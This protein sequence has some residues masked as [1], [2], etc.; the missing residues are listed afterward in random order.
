MADDAT[1][2]GSIVGH[3]RLDISDWEAKL[4]E[5]ELKAR[6][7]A[8]VDPDIRVDV[9]SASALAK[10]EAVRVAAEAV[11]GV[12]A[13]PRVSTAASPVSAG[14]AGKV[15]ALTVA[16]A[17]LDAVTAGLEAAQAAD[18]EEM[19]QGSILALRESINME[20]LA[21]AER[22]AAVA[23]VERAAADEA[24]AKAS[25]DSSG[26]DKLRVSRMG[27]IV[28]AVAAL[29]PLLGPLSAYIVG[30][31]GAF[32]GMAAAGVLAVI[33]IRN[34]MKDGTAEGQ[35]YSDGLQTL[36]GDLNGLAATSAT[37]MLSSFQK[38]VGL[39]HA[40][41]PALNGQISV[42]SSMLGNIGTTVLQGV[43]TALRVLNPLFVQAGEYVQDL[44]DGFQ[45][46]T[47]DGGLQKFATYAQQELPK[48]AETLGSLATAALHII[49]ALAPLGNATLTI[50]TGFGNAINALPNGL[51]LTLAVSITGVVI[52]TKAMK[53]L[54]PIINQVK[55]AFTG[56]GGAVP[57]GLIIGF[58]NEI[59]ILGAQG[60]AN[61]ANDMTGMSRAYAA[62]D[63]AMSTGDLGSSKAK[64]AAADISQTLKT[65]KGELGGFAGFVIDT[66]D[67]L[68]KNGFGWLAGPAQA[69][70]QGTFGKAST[71][72]NTYKSATDAVAASQSAA[73]GPTSALTAALQAQST[74]ADMLKTSFDLLNGTN[75]SVEQSQTAMAAANN[76]VTESFAQNGLAIDGSSAAAVANQ[77][78]IQNAA[79]A[80]QANAE[81]I[82]TQTGS[83]NAGTTAFMAS[84]TA[85]EQQLAAQ[86]NLTPAVQ[87][88]IDKLYAIPPELATKLSVDNAAA[89]TA[90]ANTQEALNLLPRT[91]TIGVNMPA[92]TG[93]YKILTNATGGAVPS[94][95]SGGGNGFKPVGTD[96]VPAMLTPKEFVVKA[97]S[98]EHDP[99]FIKAY[100]DNPQQAL[101]NY[102]GKQKQTVINNYF[103]IY[104]STSADA[105][106]QS[107]V[108]FLAGQGV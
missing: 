25:N 79:L 10:L 30:V 6:E 83:T 94:Y 52:A 4:K 75:L 51:L 46:W 37:A 56:L 102:G 59:A 103:T 32:G 84:K 19:R 8:R 57:I 82:T 68:E 93:G 64:K 58:A 29:I 16:M 14:A 55:G 24:G 108:H 77:Q 27:L 106:A 88:Y 96:T 78:A 35:K 65:A 50:L 85:L 66:S 42:F 54:P 28:A 15:D 3:L 80:A 23:A 38:A 72:L 5:A 91:I 63:K 92:T 53:A 48:V 11:D 21:A 43:L 89:L 36:K 97:S 99:Q 7:L 90:I 101:D 33:G 105:T 95:L 60:L 100:N 67:N 69:F 20:A 1:T 34:A 81:A 39:I 73:T 17:K 71:T 74:T 9:D 44:A 70:L 22:K 2:E 26:A 62:I 87:A 104:E 45:Q 47:S 61:I 18:N 12:S 98:A 76:S 107:V 40:D 86:G 31:G 41:M 13:G 49:E